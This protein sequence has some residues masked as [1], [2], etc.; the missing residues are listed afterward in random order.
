[1]HNHIITSPNVTVEAEAD[2]NEDDEDDDDDDDD[3]DYDDEDGDD[4]DEEEEE[5]GNTRE[6]KLRK[7][8]GVCCSTNKS[9]PWNVML[10]D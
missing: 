2:V 9:R 8:S 5:D 3:D 6:G 4:D 10:Q 7:L 1:M